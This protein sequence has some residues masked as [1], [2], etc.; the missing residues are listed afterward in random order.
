[1]IFKYKY[2]GVIVDEILSF[3]AHLNNTIKLVVHKMS[4]LNRI[5]FYITED[6]AIKT[7][8]TMILPYMD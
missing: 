8:K 3:R 5:M 4:M 2:L 6:A 7:Y 1:M